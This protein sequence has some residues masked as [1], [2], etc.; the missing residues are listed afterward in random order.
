MILRDFV[1]FSI[2]V[3]LTA[4]ATAQERVTVGTE[5]L[6][7]N[8]ALF[9]AAVQGYFKT[10]GLDVEIMDFRGPGP[11]VEAL[12]AGTADFGL[13][14]LS[15]AAFNLAGHG[16]IMAI[17][18]QVREKNDY[19]GNEVIAANPAYD[20]GLRKFDDLANKVVGIVS[21]GSPFHYQLGQIASRKGFDLAGVTLK[22]YFSL[23]AVARA[24]ADG[25]VDAA[26]LPAQYARDLLTASEAKL[27]GWYSEID[28]QQLGALFTSAKMIETRR[29]IVEKFVRAYRRGAAEYASALLRHD[30]YRKPVSDSLSQAAAAMIARYVYPGQRSAAAVVESGV[31]FMDAQARLDAADIARQL[32]WY[33]AQGL[34]EQS[35]DARAVID[36]SFIK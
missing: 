36:L 18:A 2:I 19:E 10:E 14:A 6:A 9:L 12:A 26:I 7:S 15:P 20:K 30:R 21:L 16:T 34:V 33:K 27:I 4:P 31:Y 3:G 22:P 23:D 1:I 13:T 25:H 24:V 8:G 32:E 5:R 11:V 17:A 28:E 35:V 29:P